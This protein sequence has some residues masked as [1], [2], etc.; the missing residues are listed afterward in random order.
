VKKPNVEGVSTLIKAL[1]ILEA[2]A[3]DNEISITDISERFAINKSTVYRFLDTFKKLGYVKQN[4][5]NDKYSLTLKLFELGSKS[6]ERMDLITEARPVI[7]E[8]SKLTEET[9]HLAALDEES[10]VYLDK[11]DSLHLL[12]MFSHIGR[13]APAYCTGLGKALL[14][15]ASDD[16]I[17][18]ALSKDKIVKHTENT[19]TE[20]SQLLKA[21]EEI[22][23]QGYAIDN[24]EHEI[25]IKCAA[26]PIR[27]RTGNVVAAISVSCPVQRLDD[28]RM[29]NFIKNVMLAA[30]NISVRLGCGASVMKYVN[31]K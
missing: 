17:G 30:E 18:K 5:S 6:V 23:A 12:R 15:W 27:D 20:P 22:R 16:I 26:A 9:I 13:R 21:F 2:V 31:K 11:I 28:E 1:R 14:A 8:L 19:L 25:G 10:V 4:P 3:N 29:N 24:E 7:E